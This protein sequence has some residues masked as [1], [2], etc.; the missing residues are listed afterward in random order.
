MMVCVP[1]M[2][3]DTADVVI[4]QVAIVE[5]KVMM[6]ED[7]VKMLEIATM[8]VVMVR[9]TKGAFMEEAA[10]TEEEEWKKEKT[11]Q[12]K[13]G[14]LKLTEERALKDMTENIPMTKEGA[15]MMTVEKPVVIGKTA[16]SEGLS[17]TICESRPCETV[18]RVEGGRACRGGVGVEKRGWRG[19]RRGEGEM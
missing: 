6:T 12:M 10:K 15:V 13:E 7:A 18:S 2:K 19:R 16:L 5:D 17:G 8:L 3:K 4:V 9:M 1:L 11:P 14:V